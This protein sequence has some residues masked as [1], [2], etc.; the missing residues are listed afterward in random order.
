MLASLAAHQ[1]RRRHHGHRNWSA[2]CCHRT[3]TYPC[4]PGPLKVVIVRLVLFKLL[5]RNLNFKLCWW[6]NQ[7]QVEFILLLQYVTFDEYKVS[8]IF[9]GTK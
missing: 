9:C 4:H 7:V 3:A 2:L 5:S 6:D 1:L 8:L